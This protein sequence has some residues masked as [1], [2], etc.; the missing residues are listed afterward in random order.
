MSHAPDLSPHHAPP[1]LPH[2][3]TSRRVATLSRHDAP[4]M[5]PQCM[6]PPSSFA[7]PATTTYP[8]RA[9]SPSSTSHPAHTVAPSHARPPAWDPAAAGP[10][11]RQQRPTAPDPVAPRRSNLGF[12]RKEAEAQVQSCIRSG[13]CSGRSFFF[14][15]WSRQRSGEGVGGGILRVGGTPTPVSCDWFIEATTRISGQIHLRSGSTPTSTAKVVTVLTLHTGVRFC[16]R[17]RAAQPTGACSPAHDI[18]GFRRTRVCMGCS[19][20][21]RL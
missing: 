2:S 5:P 14:L 13:R 1:Q 19:P 11:R 20:W 18:D 3:R 6:E 17:G 7:P 21:T 9:R 10:Q 12:R 16:P 4:P 15:K 8:A